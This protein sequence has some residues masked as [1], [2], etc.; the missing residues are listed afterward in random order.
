M[1]MICDCDETACR[2]C[3]G[4]CERDP[5]FD[6]GVFMEFDMPVHDEIWTTERYVCAFCAPALEAVGWKRRAEP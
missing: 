3:S 1:S 5:D 2:F 4:T 6:G